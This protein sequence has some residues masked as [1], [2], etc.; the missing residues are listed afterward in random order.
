MFVYIIFDIII[1]V[2]LQKE[3]S[4]VILW[5]TPLKYIFL[6]PLTWKIFRASNDNIKRLLPSLFKSIIGNLV[7]FDVEQEWYKQILPKITIFE[8]VRYFYKH[9]TRH[10][11]LCEYGSIYYMIQMSWNSILILPV[12]CQLPRFKICLTFS[13]VSHFWPWHILY[14]YNHF[15]VT[16][17]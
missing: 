13:Y 6:L 12:F 17:A 2:I 3:D 14:K 4:L 1:Y 15:L 10:K 8:Y 11:Q 9:L 7:F 16:Y 5:Q